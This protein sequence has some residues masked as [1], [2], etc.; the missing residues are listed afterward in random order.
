M[1]CSILVSWLVVGLVVL[2]LGLVGVY[3]LFV[4]AISVFRV[5]VSLCWL[6]VGGW[7][8]M[9]WLAD[10]VFGLFGFG[11]V[12]FVVLLVCLVFCAWLFAVMFAFWLLVV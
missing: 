6:A 9:L 11:L 12:L 7:F 10:C 1:V 8:I 2:L 4:L 3:M 5:L